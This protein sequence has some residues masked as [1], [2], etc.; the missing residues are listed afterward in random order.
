MKKNKEEQRAAASE[1][2][3]KATESFIKS[4]QDMG[5]NIPEGISSWEEVF[6]QWHSLV[7]L[8]TV[9]PEALQR[10]LEGFSLLCKVWRKG[11]LRLFDEWNDCLMK[12]ADTCRNASKEE[13][14]T[15][16][17]MK[18]CL[19]SYEEFFDKLRK[20]RFSFAT[21]QM[22][23]YFGYVKSFLPEDIEMNGKQEN[24]DK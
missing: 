23:A 10:S 18:A 20:A 1:Y 17:V 19:M 11:S 5:T 12:L 13:D 7:K 8:A 22:K 9:N 16:H 24:N 15:Q 3:R 14:D 4:L 6:R 21:E 2:Y